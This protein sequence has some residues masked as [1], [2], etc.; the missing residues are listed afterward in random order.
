MEILEKM[1]TQVSEKRI[2]LINLLQLQTKKWD[3]RMFH[4][5]NMEQTDIIGEQ[6]HR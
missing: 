3:Q 6:V 5:R 2:F 1:V 4:T